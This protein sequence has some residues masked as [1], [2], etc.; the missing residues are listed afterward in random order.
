MLH[1]PSPPLDAHVPSPPITYT[2]CSCPITSRCSCPITYTRCSCTI[3]YTRCSCTITYARCS[4]PITYATCSCTITYTRCS[5]TITYARCSCPITYARCSCPITY[6]RCSCPITYTRHQLTTIGS[7]ISI[8]KFILEAWVHVK[9]QGSRHLS[10]PEHYRQQCLMTPIVLIWDGCSCPI[11]YTR[12]QLT[13]IGS[14]ISI[15]KFILEAWV[16]VKAQGSRHLSKPEHYRQQCLMTPIVLIWDGCVCCVLWTRGYR[17]ISYR[18]A[19]ACHHLSD[20]H[21]LHV[22][23][24]I[25][26]AFYLVLLK[27]KLNRHHHQYHEIYMVSEC[28]LVCECVCVC[29]WCVCAIII[30]QVF[31]VL[32]DTCVTSWYASVCLVA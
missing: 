4:C 16:H 25:C 21:I 27:C 14:V 13:T 7:V 18:M 24:A 2:R 23:Y 29:V 8:T 1:V 31:P 15:T 19:S 30:K 6:T 10:K 32:Y 3:T 17:G 26:F 12:H 11:T 28:A 22:F 20:I 5:C 9:A